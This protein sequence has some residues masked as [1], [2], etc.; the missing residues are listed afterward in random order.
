MEDK[1][2]ILHIDWASQ[3]SRAIVCFCRMAKIPHEINEVRVGQLQQRDEKF[4]AI[5]PNMQV[6][7]ITEIDLKTGE[8]FN[9]FESHAILKY[10][11][12]SRNVAD[13]W[14]PKDP[15]K[16]MKVD[17][18]LDWH[19]QGI[20]Q[21]LGFLIFKMLF[22]P[23]FFGSETPQDVLEFQRRNQTKDLRLIESWLSKAK[24]ISGDEISIADISCACELIQG[25][26]IELDLSKYP[27]I[28]KWL[29]MM[30][31]E[32]PEMHESH[33]FMLKLAEAS[34]QK[35]KKQKQ[36]LDKPKL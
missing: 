8:Q 20:R 34:L 26:F 19:H 21:S 4:T 23:M 11:A 31:F 16:R 13:N 14:Y 5:N 28:E 2:L 1:K 36:K 22:G 33:K 17:I 12:Q 24:F 7:A 27:H 3:P 18:Y 9:L 25:R 6:P 15:I 10:L 29:Q 32:I 30:I 35:Q